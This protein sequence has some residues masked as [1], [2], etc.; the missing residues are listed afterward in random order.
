MHA[1]DQREYAHQKAN[2]HAARD[3]APVKTPQIGAQHQMRKGR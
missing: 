3:A 2:G 1:G